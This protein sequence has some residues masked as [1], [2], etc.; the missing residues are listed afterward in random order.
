MIES[1]KPTVTQTILSKSGYDLVPYVSKYYPSNFN[2][3]SFY[4]EIY[5]V[6]LVLPDSEKYLVTYFIEDF[7]TKE[8]LNSFSNFSKYTAAK[9]SSLLYSFSIEKLRTGNY[10]VCIEV[11]NRE[12]SLL[13]ERKLFFQ[14]NNPEKGEALDDLS[15][16][17]LEK[18]FVKNYTNRD[19]LAILIDCLRPIASVAEVNYSENQLNSGDIEMMKRFFFSFWQRRNPA[20]PEQEWIAYKE[21][22]DE[23]N[24]LF[25][26]SI[27]NKKGFASDRGRVYLKYGS[28][29]IRSISD[30]EPTAYPYEI[31]QYDKTTD[32]QTNRR[33]VFYCPYSGSNDFRLIHSDARGETYD[34][35]W[36]F[37]IDDRNTNIPGKN[38]LDKEIIDDNSYGRQVD[39]LYK[40]PR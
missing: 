27:R 33:F 35:R 5:N 16:L 24:R 31:W 39:D 3:L 8:K 32:G 10:N 12:N 18:T 1:F 21:K 9:V 20:N 34:A 15:Q 6:N 11:R 23:T 38:N 29:T 40:N 4:A 7:D 30:H 36:R 19:S 17:S 2:T 28:P 14:R 37:K 26:T 22:V 13:A 25:S